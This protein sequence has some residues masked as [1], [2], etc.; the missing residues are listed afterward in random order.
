MNKESDLNT[1]C[2][3]VSGGVDSSG[4]VSVLLDEGRTVEPLYIRTGMI[5]EDVEQYW[6][7]QYLNTIA[8]P[9]LHPLQAISLPLKDVYLDHWSVT[10]VDTP[11]YSAPDPDVYLPGRNIVLVA[12][13]AI[14]LLTKNANLCR[15]NLETI[16]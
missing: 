4:L 1:V 7:E 9:R 8:C 11:G 13:A 10:G 14:P 6:L 12:K 3:L 2:A 16:G 5:W 15:D